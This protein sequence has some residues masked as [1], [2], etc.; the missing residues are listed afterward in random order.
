M[1]SNNTPEDDRQYTTTHGTLTLKN[2]PFS[3]MH[4]ESE[5]DIEALAG[6][7]L[8]ER[9]SRER[10]VQMFE[11]ATVEFTPYEDDESADKPE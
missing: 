1:T 11:E 4:E 6:E 3:V 7:E 10:A 2:I 8:D 9:T 5:T